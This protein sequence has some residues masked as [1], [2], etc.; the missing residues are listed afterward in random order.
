[1]RN[2]KPL[3]K[4]DV[5]R[6]ATDQ[7]Q[8]KGNTSSND[9]K[10]QLRNEGYWAEQNTVSNWLQEVG[11]EQDYHVE[12]RTSTGGRT[13]NEYS[14]RT[15]TKTQQTHSVAVVAANPAVL[16]LV[17]AAIE[18]V[19]GIHVDQNEKFEDVNATEP[20]DLDEILD[21]IFGQYGVQGIAIDSSKVK[22]SPFDPD[23]I[24]VWREKTPSDLAIFI[25]TLLPQSQQSQPQAIPVQVIPASQS[26]AKV[27]KPRTRVTA[28]PI[29]VLPSTATVTDIK[30]GSGHYSDN[31]W[32]VYSNVTKEKRIFSGTETRDH[33]RGAFAKGL[34]VTKEQSRARRV[35]HLDPARQYPNL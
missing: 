35:K 3:T 22:G 19:L 26:V 8:S 13:Y 29:Y 33:V 25:E 4:P 17:L 2:A 23:A 7:I 5:L 32:I 16:T 31:D 6:V 9:V 14:V 10:E 27:H 30:N 28:Q 34:N 15:S 18:N 12:Q 21:E 20:S 1:M 24:I 11:K